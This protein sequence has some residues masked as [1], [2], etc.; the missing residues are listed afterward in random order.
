[1]AFPDLREGVKVATLNQATH[2]LEYQLPTN[3]HAYDFSGHLAR[4]SSR[5]IDLEVTPNHRMYVAAKTSNARFEDSPG[6]WGL[7]EADNCPA[8]I[9]MKKNAVW[10]G[11]EQEHFA[12]GGYLIPMDDWLELLGYYV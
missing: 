1:V 4:F 6:K 2:E 3:Y 11:G 9:R 8:H 7:S 10:R 5:H 12:I